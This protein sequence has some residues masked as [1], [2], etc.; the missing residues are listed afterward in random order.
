MVVVAAAEEVR[1]Q[2]GM[3]NIQKE[4]NASLSSLFLGLF[5]RNLL[6]SYASLCPYTNFLAT[7]P[8]Q[9][10]GKYHVSFYSSTHTIIYACNC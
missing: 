3:S 8:S 7:R 6:P 1:W 10:G 5:Y 2:E 9:Q 4:C